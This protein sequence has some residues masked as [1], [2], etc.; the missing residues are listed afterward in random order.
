[1]EE[2]KK[3]GKKNSEVKVNKKTPV[4]SKKTNTTKKKS[5]TSKNKTVVK[6]S[7]SNTAKK[8][9]TNGKKKTSTNITSKKKNS[10]PKKVATPKVKS[11]Q[12]D[13]SIEEKKYVISET[14]VQEVEMN[15]ND[16]SPI[17]ASTSMQK[18]EIPVM[19]Y[20][21]AM[22]AIVWV[23]IIAFLGF[24][25][26]QTHLE[27]LYQEGYFNQKENI[28]KITL[29]EVEN[30]IKNSKEN[31]IFIL[32]N[33]H[34]EKEHYELEKDL[35]QIIQDYHF[36]DNF[37]YVDITNVKNSENCDI[38]CKINQKFGEETIKNLPAIVYLKDKKVIDVAQ[39]EDKKVLEESDFGK[40]LDS[41]EFQK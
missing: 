40:L 37:Y 29:E 11:E 22:I 14:V 38:R 25:L 21:I 3:N 13:S 17:E 6:E 4:S 9:N 28:K 32:F 26:Y 33:F 7:T 19:N 34:Y 10:T 36:E 27:A 24:H 35:E 1:M 8:A 15:S 2:K 18:H 39:R 12:N 16:I 23:F 41:Y 30:V 31:N 5:A 20:F